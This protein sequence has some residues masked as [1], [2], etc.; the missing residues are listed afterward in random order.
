MHAL[1][2][3][4]TVRPRIV[5]TKAASNESP[6]DVVKRIIDKR[7]A[8]DK[9]RAE[10]LTKLHDE[11]RAMA[12]EEVELAKALLQTPFKCECKVEKKEKEETPVEAEP[13]ASVE[14]P[15][16]VAVDG[17]TD[18]DSVFVDKSERF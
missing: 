3:K 17:S 6:Q 1:L 7:R 18:L 4:H 2:S 13:K 15:S 10:K 5:S 11:L 14:D 9:E 16:K 12:L 8:L